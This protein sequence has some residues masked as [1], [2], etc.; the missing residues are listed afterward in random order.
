MA[1][2]GRFAL[3]SLPPVPVQSIRYSD[4]AAV[5]GRSVVIWV[6]VAMNRLWTVSRREVGRLDVDVR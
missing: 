1:H 6:P 5:S 4:P 2:Y 3:V